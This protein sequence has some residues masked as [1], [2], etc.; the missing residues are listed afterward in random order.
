MQQNI[1]IL[2]L[3]SITWKKSIDL[4]AKR[5]S[6]AAQYLIAKSRASG[7]FSYHILT[8]LHKALVMNNIEYSSHE[9]DLKEYKCLEHVQN[10]LMRAFLGLGKTAP[11][12]GL[13]G[14]MNWRPLH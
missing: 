3:L 7:N 4:I 8:H 5:A 6:K 12:A 14:E 13:S 1:H 2:G 9:W 11:I 10:N